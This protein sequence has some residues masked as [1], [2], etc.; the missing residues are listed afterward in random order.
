M[1]ERQERPVDLERRKAMLKIGRFASYTAPAMTVLLVANRAEAA[2][3]GKQGWRG[4]RSR[5]RKARL[6][7][8]KRLLARLFG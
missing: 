6:A 7:F 5:R 8:V 2:S 1:N 4:R 3:S